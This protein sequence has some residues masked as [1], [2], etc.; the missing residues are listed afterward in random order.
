MQLL[1]WQ[2]VDLICDIQIENVFT[3]ICVS[4][5]FCGIEENKLFG[6]DS[7]TFGGRL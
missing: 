5:G 6:T 2:K 4:Y 3:V 7:N 1:P